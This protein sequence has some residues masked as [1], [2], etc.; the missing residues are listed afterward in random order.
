MPINK[1][2]SANCFVAPKIYLNWMAEIEREKEEFPVLGHFVARELNVR[3]LHQ[4]TKLH[5]RDCE[6]MWISWAIGT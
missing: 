6:I 2:I 3:T 1:Q 4:I 5:K